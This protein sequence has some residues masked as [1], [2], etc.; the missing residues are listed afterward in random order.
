MW[1]LNKNDKAG[2]ARKTAPKRPQRVAGARSKNVAT[3]GSKR[4]RVNDDG[5][6]AQ[7]VRT[8]QRSALVR[9]TSY[10]MAGALGLGICTV[11]L[12]NSTIP[13]RVADW[14]SDT[15]HQ[16]FV[17]AGFVVQDV[18]VVGRHR[19]SR[20][21]LANALGAQRGM[22]ILDLSPEAARQRLEDLP[23][24]AEARVARL[25]PDTVHVVLIEREP[26]AIWQ[27][28]NNLTLV[29]REG[30][31]IAGVDIGPYAALPIIAGEGAPEHAAEI[32][33]LLR[34]EPR[35]G[36]KVDAAVRVGDRR[37]N[38]RLTNGVTI[39]LPELN[40]GK[41]WAFLSDL[42]Q[43]QKLLERDIE[44]VDLRQDS[45]ITIRAKKEDGVAGGRESR[46]RVI[47]KTGKDA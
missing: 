18:T 25:L 3:P 44:L 45:R 12:I 21:M 4:A 16:T 5:L 15:V 35:L 46:V 7:L 19:T 6:R 32:L 27:H 8:W 2:S 37:W 38:V 34:A 20:D 9:R 13:Q 47:M 26:F 43:D 29:D 31:L 1:P 36:S 39:A 11:L 22:P 28:Q 10:G 42:E 23:W 41:A 40:P 33:D 17:S 30:T 24:V 14:T